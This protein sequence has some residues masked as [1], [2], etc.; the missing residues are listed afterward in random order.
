MTGE[1]LNYLLVAIT[2]VVLASVLA[3]CATLGSDRLIPGRKILTY[4]GEDGIEVVPAGEPPLIL[5][6]HPDASELERVRF[7]TSALGYNRDEV[8]GVLAKVTEENKRL[9]A[10]LAQRDALSGAADTDD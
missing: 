1:N 9:R 8:D 7:A 4:V 6:N 2:F 10:E 3:G 5:S